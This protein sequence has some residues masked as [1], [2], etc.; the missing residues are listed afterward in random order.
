MTIIEAQDLHKHYRQKK[1]VNGLSV[2]IADKKITGIIGRNGAGKT[3][4]LKLVAGYYRPNKGKLHVF[5]EKPF[6]NINASLNTV[7]VD[8][9]M[10]FPS[11]LMLE[12]ILEEGKRFYPNWDEKLAR[13]L[14]NYFSLNPRQGHQ[15]LSKGMKSTFNM[16]FGLA[17]HCELTIFDEPTT[18]M[19]ESVRKDF[20]RAL[21]KD[22]LHYPRTILLS[23]HHLDEMEDLLEDV[24]LIKDGTVCEH[25]SIDELKEMAIGV[26]GDTASINKWLDGAETLYEQTLTGQTKYVVAYQPNEAKKQEGLTLGL[27]FKRVSASDICVYLTESRKG[28]ID[29]VFSDND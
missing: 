2:S 28:G 15:N 6:N 21:M 18:G 8:D 19:D 16:I 25:R 12:E 9:L 3:T 22:Y 11:S 13:N 23:S 14:F 10:Y 1:A 27:E 7:F 24:L 29:D 17:A 5:G 26:R 20:Y 4:F